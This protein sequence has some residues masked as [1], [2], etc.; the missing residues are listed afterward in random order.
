MLIYFN[1]FTALESFPMLTWSYFEKGLIWTFTSVHPPV[2]LENQKCGVKMGSTRVILSTN[3][4]LIIESL[5]LSQSFTI[6]SKKLN[7]QNFLISSVLDQIL[8]S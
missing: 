3:H 5:I 1:D 6:N 8:S 2:T 7:R 4:I